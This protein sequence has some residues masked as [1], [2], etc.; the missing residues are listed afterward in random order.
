MSF[1]NLPHEHGSMM[2]RDFADPDG[3]A[4]EMMWM[5]PAVAERDAHVS[6]ASAS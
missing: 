5:D 6:G 2:S 4:W 1:V 3:H